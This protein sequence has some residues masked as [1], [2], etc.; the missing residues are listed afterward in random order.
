MLIQFFLPL[1]LMIIAYGLIFFT[2]SRKSKEFGGMLKFRSISYN[3]LPAVYRIDLSGYLYFK[4][5]LDTN[6][7]EFSTMIHV[8]M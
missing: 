3:L 4:I 5:V 1:T 8:D 6:I 2:I 7:F